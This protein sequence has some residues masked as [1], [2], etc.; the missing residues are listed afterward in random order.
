MKRLIKVSER[1]CRKSYECA[2]CK[3][4]IP[5]TAFV[6]A[7]TYKDDEDNY[8]T[9]K[10]CENCEKYYRRKDPEFKDKA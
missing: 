4:E 7:Y 3:K 5:S 10:I 1:I 8:S 9:M 2:D 6:K